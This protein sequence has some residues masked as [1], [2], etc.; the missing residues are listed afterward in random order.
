MIKQRGNED[1]IAL[2]LQP[3]AMEK[4]GEN[5]T[6]IAAGLAGLSLMKLNS[7]RIA[8]YWEGGKG[9]GRRAKGERRW[10]R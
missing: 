5:S 4:E 2:A 8:G 3:Q 6:K 10:A 7:V 1:L 9:D